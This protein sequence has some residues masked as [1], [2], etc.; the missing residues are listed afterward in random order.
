[1]NGKP[2][3]AHMLVALGGLA[4]V[5]ATASAGPEFNILIGHGNPVYAQPIRYER[6]RPA[7]TIWID[8]C[9]HDLYACDGIRAGIIEALECS[10][11]DVW[12]EGS[13][14]V[15]DTS[16]H[17]P[18][19]RWSSCEYRLSVRERCDELR[20]S[21]RRSGHGHDL[22]E[23]PVIV[24]DRYRVE[25]PVVIGAHISIG[26]RG[27]SGRDHGYREEPRIEPRFEPRLRGREDDRSVRPGNREDDRS[28]RPGNREDDRSIRPGGRQDGRGPVY[29]EPPSY[30]TQRFD[31][32]DSDVRFDVDGGFYRAGPSATW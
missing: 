20:L 29:R 23:E 15:I 27:G 32:D 24:R 19:I 4:C 11:Y 26:G 28:V 1:M 30:E 6:E 17:E 3:I 10:G 8:G 22:P 2:K 13:T 7:A 18:R 25:A 31:G 12:C 16:C 14:I 5:T 21:V 9:P